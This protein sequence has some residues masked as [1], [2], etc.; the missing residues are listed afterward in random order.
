[1]ELSQQPNTLF[2]S[3]E[4]DP[5]VTGLV[6]GTCGSV[7]PSIATEGLRPRR[8]R[9]GESNWSHPSHEDAVYLTSA[10]GLHY[11]SCARTGSYAAVLDVDV[12]L[13][14]PSNLV[15]DED[16]YALT[17]VEG[18]EWVQR[19]ALPARVAYWRENLNRTDA[20]ESL[21]VL[22]NCAYLGCIPAAAIRGVRLLSAGEVARLVLGVS[23]P[24]ISPMNFKLA[25]GANQR[26]CAW[27]MGR[28][29]AGDEELS[30]W[31]A[32]VCTPVL[33]LMTLQEAVAHVRRAA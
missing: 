22:G 4:A 10:Y 26:F 30:D 7:L 19:L 13:L 17:S 16:S 29:G 3:T 24:V 32:A 33:P 12:G 18:H 8:G 28:P 20:A 15:A 11:A 21:R 6:H 2:L 25:G 9:R 14:T 1:M 5:C 23:D 27:L 31:F